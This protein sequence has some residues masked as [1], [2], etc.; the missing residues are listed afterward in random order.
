MMVDVPTNITG[1]TRAPDSENIASANIIVYPPV[2]P[3]F[4]S[5]PQTESPNPE[6]DYIDK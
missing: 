3:A 5:I 1:Q 6:A 2:Q 4:I